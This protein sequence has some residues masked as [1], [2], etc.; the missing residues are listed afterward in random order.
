MSVVICR[1]LTQQGKY[2][3]VYVQKPP[4]GLQHVAELELAPWALELLGA[5]AER[6][7]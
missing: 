4:V 7:T 3:G 1:Y 2:V 6:L 5:P